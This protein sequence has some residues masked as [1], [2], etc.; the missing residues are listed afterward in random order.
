MSLS[1]AG[2]GVRRLVV[3]LSPRHA[4]YGLGHRAGAAGGQRR[5]PRACF[6]S[7]SS[8][9]AASA[10]A[11]VSRPF[12]LWDDGEWIGSDATRAHLQQGQ[13]AAWT[14]KEKAGLVLFGSLVRVPTHTCYRRPPSIRPF[15]LPNTHV[16]RLLSFP[17]AQVA[18]TTALGV[19]QSQRYY[20]KLEQIDQRAQTLAQAPVPL[21]TCVRARECVHARTHTWV[22][23]Y[24][25]IVNPQM[26]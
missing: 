3:R 7:S 18:G 10:A 6:S 26:F 19:W 21:P 8:S 24:K 5:R 15:A 2:G 16:V 25:Y 1:T 20:W 4:G 9:S 13:A 23:A 14:G 22:C 11:A 17:S 12:R